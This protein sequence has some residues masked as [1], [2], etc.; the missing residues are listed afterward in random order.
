MRC[1]GLGIGKLIEGIVKRLRDDRRLEILVYSALILTAVVIFAVSGSISCEG[2][3]SK[4]GYEGASSASGA[5]DERELEERLAAILSRIEGAGSVSVMVKLEPAGE[6][7]SSRG[8]GLLA[9]DREYEAE[10]S[11]CG[12]IVVAQGAHDAKVRVML[13]AA[14]TSLLGVGPDRVS[15]FPMD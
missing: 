5:S 4:G 9:S 11:V 3:T 14:V 1:I 8:F 10:G 12:V 6:G 15:V 2:R 13:S 7:A